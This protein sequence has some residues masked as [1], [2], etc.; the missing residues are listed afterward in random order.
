MELGSRM[1]AFDV[2]KARDGVDEEYARYPKLVIL[3]GDHSVALAA[4]RALHELYR[5]PIAVAHFDAHCDVG[6][7][8]A[9]LV[10]KR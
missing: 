10:F 1:P 9:L 5:E 4:L 6:I 8:P 3:G 2:D 7:V